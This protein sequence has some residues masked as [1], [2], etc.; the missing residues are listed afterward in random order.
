[1]WCGKNMFW[2]C[3]C[4]FC[5]ICSISFLL[6]CFFRSVIRHVTEAICVRQHWSVRVYKV[7]VFMH[8]DMVNHHVSEC[9]LCSKMD[10]INIFLAP[11]GHS[12]IEKYSKHKIS[13]AHGVCFCFHECDSWQWD[14]IISGSSHKMESMPMREVRA[15]SRA[16]QNQFS[17]LFVNSIFGR[18]SPPSS[19]FDEKKNAIELWNHWICSFVLFLF[20]LCVSVFFFK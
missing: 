19:P 4:K 20:V 17:L 2:L 8:I 12:P 15:W 9:V 6:A 10:I 18:P 11:N 7:L 5:V 1:M 16:T 14:C 3:E 13:I